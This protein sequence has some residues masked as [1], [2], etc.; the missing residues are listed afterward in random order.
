MWASVCR[1][2][3]VGMCVSLGVGCVCIG[4]CV[5]V[6]AGVCVGDITY[7]NILNPHRWVS[8]S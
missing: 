2:V 4:V 3:Y 6:C 7:L 8:L 5:C 1:C